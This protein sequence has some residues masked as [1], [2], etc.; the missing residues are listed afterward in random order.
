MT[1]FCLSVC[2][3]SCAVAASNRRQLF[4]IAATTRRLSWW[5]SASR[6]SYTQQCLHWLAECCSVLVNALLQILSGTARQPLFSVYL[7]YQCMFVRKF[8]PLQTAAATGLP[9]GLLYRVSRENCDFYPYANDTR[10]RKL[11]P[12]SGTSFWRRFLVRV[13]LALDGRISETARDTH[14]GC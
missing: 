8:S 13:S 7:Q 4:H 10:T 14:R 11:A 9:P 6:Y 5:N 2:H 3:V 12:D 1:S